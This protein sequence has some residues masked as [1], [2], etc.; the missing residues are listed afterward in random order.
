MFRGRTA[1]SETVD[2][3]RRFE[4]ILLRCRVEQ[5]RFDGKVWQQ[6]FFCRLWAGKAI[7][8]S[9]WA[10]LPKR[11]ASAFMLERIQTYSN[12]LPGSSW[13]MGCQLLATSTR[14]KER[15][16]S[17][18]GG[19]SPYQKPATQ[20]KDKANISGGDTRMLPTTGKEKRRAN[21][22]RCSRYPLALSCC[23]HRL[24]SSG[25]SIDISFRCSY[26]H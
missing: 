9:C 5:P 25:D 10:P 1:S 24:V 15:L 4:I 17:N 3:H 16:Y 13:L 2:F 23:L 22:L 14:S 7:P 19:T 18:A 11:T 20:I 8:V 12:N 21:V 6:Q 26:H